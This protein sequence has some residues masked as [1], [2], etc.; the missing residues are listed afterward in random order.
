MVVVDYQSG[1]VVTT[2]PIGDGPDAAAYDPGTRTVFS[3]NGEDGTL[4]VVKVEA[5]DKY[6]PA[7]VQTKKGARTMALD[8]K[9]H[10]V[11]LSSADYGSPPA[12]T[13]SNPHPRPSIVPGS[14]KL[15][16][17]SQ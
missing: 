8:L 11:Y 13:A 10:K 6:M 14:F 16:V 3:S 15:L 12:A 1:K 4:T 2:V 9:T 7:T 17:L 5:H